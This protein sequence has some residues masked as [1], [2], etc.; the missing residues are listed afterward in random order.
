[1][2]SVECGLELSTSEDIVICEEQTIQLEGD[3][4]GDYFSFN[5]TSDHGYFNDWN[6]NPSVFID[7]APC[8]FTLTAL[9]PTGTNLID[10][11]DFESGNIGFTTDYILVILA[12]LM[13][14]LIAAI[15]PARRASHI[16]VARQLSRR[17]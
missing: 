14:G 1:M 12:V 17:A 10:N 4:D 3:I 5:W 8:E 16:D 13:A 11:G 2:P 6:L 7:N 9:A 15:V